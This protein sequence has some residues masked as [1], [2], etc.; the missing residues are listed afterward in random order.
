M[1][2]QNMSGVTNMIFL[3]LFLQGILALVQNYFNKTY[4]PN[5]QNLECEQGHKYLFS[6]I[7]HNW[8]DSIAECRLYGGWLVDIK[9]Q[10][11]QNCLMRYGISQGYNDWFHTDANDQGSYGTW[12]TQAPTTMSHGFLR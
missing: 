4:V 12:F 10:K 11:E 1:G 8:E 2:R 7:V 3:F 5:W 6:E 9:D